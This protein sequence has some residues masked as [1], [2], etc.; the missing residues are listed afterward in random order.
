MQSWWECGRNINA[1]TVRESAGMIG[2]KDCT[3]LSLNWYTTEVNHCI[4]AAQQN[5][6]DESIKHMNKLTTRFFF[7]GND[8]FPMYS[9]NIYTFYRVCLI[10]LILFKQEPEQFSVK[11]WVNIE[12]TFENWHISMSGNSCSN[13]ISIWRDRR[14]LGQW[15]KDSMKYENMLIGWPEK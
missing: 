15:H 14:S 8:Q 10:I 13:L 3:I 12:S 6:Y 5:I 7:M 11:L 9:I 1:W 2:R 4:H